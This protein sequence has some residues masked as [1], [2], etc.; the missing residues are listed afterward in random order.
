MKINP[1]T[2]TL[3]L[4]LHSLETTILPA[5]STPE[6]QASLH[7]IKL[8]LLDLLKRQ[9]PSIPI[10]LSSIQNGEA[11]ENEINEVL[12]STYIPHIS[13]LVGV[14]ERLLSFEVLSEIYDALTTRLTEAGVRLAERGGEGVEPLLRKIAKW[15]NEY[16]TALL[17][18][19]ATPFG[20]D[21]TIVPSLYE[22]S[23]KPLTAAFLTKFLQEKRGTELQVTSLTPI[24]GGFGKQTFRALIS[25]DDGSEERLIIRKADPAPIMVHS[26]FNVAAE[27]AL[28]S[29]LAP[30]GFPCPTAKELYSGTE[31]DG[32]FFSMSEVAGEIPRSFLDNGDKQT[33]GL[34]E[35]ILLQMAEI[36]ARLHSIP[37]STFAPLIE[38]NEGAKAIN[39]NIGQRMRRNIASWKAYMESESSNHLPSPF[40]VWLFHWLSTHIENDVRSPVLL[41]GDYAVHNVLQQEGRITGV[42][43][44]EGAEFGAPEMDLAYV[45]PHVEKHMEWSK[46]LERYKEAGGREIDERRYKF[47]AA[48][49]CMKTY[50][51]GLRGQR[52]IQR[53]LNR[54]I[55]YL[56]VEFGFAPMFGGLGLSA[57]SEDVK[58][59]VKE[60]SETSTVVTSGSEEGKVQ[61]SEGTSPGDWD[62][63]GEA[64]AAEVQKKLAEVVLKS[65]DAQSVKSVDF[66][67]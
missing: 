25:H 64:G 59:P 5:A 54:E 13:A 50:L 27:F 22:Q 41:H 67:D 49:G 66:A 60:E 20:D 38:K 4:I 11:L 8:G 36:L 65:A 37:L 2:T 15:E 29:L 18:V 39:D 31:I 26:T 58:E 12:D 42:L 44:W 48:Y 40:I 51:G 43:D 3:S 19:T 21:P 6:A 57:A 62:E 63:N 30:T 28:L 53:G 35:D 33:A 32:W 46:F 47:G 9:G 23:R 17:G 52:N 34:D 7:V 45:K 24:T 10:L 61:S 16:T 1:T 55:R 14:P 56:M